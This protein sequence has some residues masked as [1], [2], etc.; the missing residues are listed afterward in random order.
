[1]SWV[2]D[3]VPLSTLA[4]NISNRSAGWKVP[5]KRGENLTIP[6]RNGAQWLPNKAFD[7]GALTLNMWV[8]GADP[9]TGE[10]PTERTMYQQARDN[11]DRLTA[12]FAQSH[13]LLQVTQISGA[14]YGLQNVM[15][16]PNFSTLAPTGPRT[17]RNVILNPAMRRTGQVTQA[18]NLYANPNVV[19][20]QVP[21]WQPQFENLVPDPFAKLGRTASTGPSPGGANYWAPAN[22]EAYAAG[23]TLPASLWTTAA[24]TTA[25]VQGSTGTDQAN[26]PLGGTKLFRVILTAGL[27]A[28]ASLGIKP[29]FYIAPG[30]APLVRFRM[31]RGMSGSTV[32]NVQIRLGSADSGG[33]AV[34]WSSWQSFA[35]PAYNSNA[36][37]WTNVVINPESVFINGTTTTNAIL[38]FRTGEAWL[39]GDAFIID[40]AITH[41][42]GTDITGGYFGNTAGPFYDGDS[43]WGT[44]YNTAGNADTSSRWPLNMD[45]RWTRAIAT[46]PTSA[47]WTA[48]DRP[49]TDSSGTTLNFIAYGFITGGTQVFTQDLL[50]PTQSLPYTLAFNARA[51]TGA[52]CTVE[53]LKKGTSDADYI[54]VGSVSVVGTA[55]PAGTGQRMNGTVTTYVGPTYTPDAGDLFRLRVTVPVRTDGHPVFQFS[56]LNF[57]NSGSGAFSGDT[58]NSVNSQYTWDGAT[59]NSRSIR[60]HR[61]GKRI[62]GRHI[63]VSTI[64]PT[65][66]TQALYT[67]EIICLADGDPSAVNL[68]QINL[69]ATNRGLYARGIVL[70]ALSPLVA[71]GTPNP[72]VRIDATFVDSG[73]TVLGVVSGTAVLL[74]VQVGSGGTF[75]PVTVSVPPESIPAGAVGVRISFVMVSPRLG[76]YIEISEIGV[77]DIGITPARLGMPEYFSNTAT[78][79]WL[80]P[81]DDAQ[82]EYRITAPLGFTSGTAV[83]YPIANTL[84]AK[85]SLANQ[86]TVTIGH[87]LGATYPSARYLIGLQAASRA[88][89]SNGTKVIGIPVLLAVGFYSQGTE[90]GTA[91]PYQLSGNEIFDYFQDTVDVPGDFDEIRFVFTAQPPVPSSITVE[92]KS[93]YL[94]DNTDLSP[95][96]RLGGNGVANPDFNDALTFWGYSGAAPTAVSTT[97][98]PGYLLGIDT[99]LS[100]NPFS[101]TPGDQLNVALWAADGLR[102]T[103]YWNAVLARRN[104]MPNPSFEAAY[105]GYAGGSALL[106][107]DTEWALNG[108]Y[109]AKITPNGT[110]NYSAIYVFN[111]TDTGGSMTY[112]HLIKGHTYTISATIR[113]TV[114]QTGTLDGYAR[115]I[116][117]M[118]RRGGVNTAGAFVTAPNVPG[119]YRLS[120]TFTVPLDVQDIPIRLMNGSANSRRTGVV[121]LGTDRGGHLPHDRHQL[122]QVTVRGSRRSARLERR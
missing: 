26:N 59:A 13:R 29:A 35:M 115:S 103:L 16:N 114:P 105:V 52:T 1:M 51:L 85:S 20:G 43:G 15:T 100:G 113:I 90:V 58:A 82:S 14:A 104:L 102:S 110:L 18:K 40:Q 31:R 28:N 42:A 73:G 56:Q 32:R 60:S 121:G 6:G 108:L 23:A 70:G 17:Y 99:R 50:S 117:V 47:Y 98:G 46:G 74:N 34:T 64:I 91:A 4:F 3:D 10:L 68:E 27:A 69:P 97:K 53:L 45:T 112:L 41:I 2:I 55:T 48:T 107:R 65:G 12:L 63:V 83:P 24:N 80:G 93:I 21:L 77:Y 37:D 78:A 106:A 79:I 86:A 119:V 96:P 71:A 66:Y 22:Y 122:A 120:L 11:L 94:Y 54:A 36:A 116:N 5:S 67:G 87:P 19:T 30:Y 88:E 9:E 95:M 76:T 101:V 92:I 25:A 81:T 61:Q 62:T 7:Q 111:P 118:T 33:V 8:N 109:S 84:A 57:H 89:D 75:L 39:T 72:S 49:Y 38:Q 44:Y